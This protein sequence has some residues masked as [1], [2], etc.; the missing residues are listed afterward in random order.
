[1]LA[2]ACALAIQ[3]PCEHEE[4]RIN[5]GLEGG[6]GWND[7]PISEQA[8]RFM[9]AGRL[10]RPQRELCRK[11][12][13][14]ARSASHLS[15]R[16]KEHISMY[17]LFYEFNDRPFAASPLVEN[18]YPAES[19]EHARQT[20]IRVIERAEGPG[21]VIGQAGLGKSLLCRLVAEYF[22]A[23]FDVVLLSSARI[24]T[25]KSLLQSILFE[26]KLPYR[27]LEE[28]EL[29]LALLDFL[30]PGNSSPNGML[31]VVD[32]AHTLPLRLLDE[33]RMIT[34]LVRDSQPRARLVM[35]GNPQLEER[36]AHPKL[37]SFNQRI[38]ARC[39]LECL[40]REDTYRYVRA[41]IGA[42]G[43]DSDD[44]FS[45]DSLAAVHR[46]SDGIP[47]LINQICDHTLVLGCAGGKRQ[48]DSFCV[49]EAWADLQQLPGPWR[50]EPTQVSAEPV[51]EFGELDD[52]S[53]LQ[54]DSD[55]SSD[56]LESVA[57]DDVDGVSSKD[58][59]TGMELSYD[60]SDEV[61]D[62]G[63]ELEQDPIESLDE[64]EGGDIQSVDFEFPQVI[65]GQQFDLG[66]AMELDTPELDN[67]EV[68]F[69][70]SSE[71]ERIIYLPP[72]PDDEYVEDEVVAP[73]E[74]PIVAADP[75]ETE[76][77]EEEVIID[78]EQALAIEAFRG[79][80]AV[81]SAEGQELADLLSRHDDARRELVNSAATPDF[82]ESSVNALIAEPASGSEV[83]ETEDTS[84][85]PESPAD[86]AVPDCDSQVDVA[87]AGLSAA[88]E[89]ELSCV[90]FPD[91]S[92]TAHDDRD[93]MIVAPEEDEDSQDASADDPPAAPQR[94]EYQE[95]FAQLRKT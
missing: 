12:K 77:D 43:G 35:A 28:G 6:A 4:T 8:V 53:P 60:L 34:N 79:R 91:S 78:R 49:E 56:L 21:L 87:D 50:E 45:D 46:A 22:S 62:D 33:I 73:A 64:S 26:L 3:R 95:L 74:E 83:G 84:E 67:I 68:E 94:V 5:S 93:L 20:L 18:Y 23:T 11:Q 55:E 72:D 92:Q 40:G 71:E 24:G 80:P 9:G 48:L 30:Q 37:D 89:S 14:L 66:G 10:L 88:A 82:A 16:A 63:G 25:R 70:E 29:R 61:E 13:S 81:S 51:V 7:L 44:V 39:Y 52:F 2:P 32:E 86:T 85:S 36:F 15:N 17:E 90:A 47:R 54:L 1:M 69:S 57:E 75:F 38:A 76:F 65:I 31:L 19:I 42:V 59:S 27:E 41:Q 58:K